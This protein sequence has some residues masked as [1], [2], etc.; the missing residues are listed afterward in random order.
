VATKKITIEN[1]GEVTLVKTTA[2]RSLRLTVNTSGTVRVSLP[3]WTP[4]AAAE[5]F[6]RSHTQWIMKELS[7]RAPAKLYTEAQKVGKLHH[8]HFEKVPAAV[9]IGSRV[10]ATKIIVKYHPGET[11]TARSVQERAEKAI[12][13]ALRKETEQLLPPRIRALA[14]KH[15]FRYRSIAAKQLKRRWGSC[16]SH[17]NL[18]FNFFLME[19][20]WEYID[21]VILHELTHTE[22]LHHGPA[23]WE[24]LKQ[25]CPAALDL[26]RRMREYRPMIGG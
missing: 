24:R 26:R 3:Y 18:V 21:Y 16:D 19:L 7:E 14:E 4:Y 22:H 8:L 15:G 5:A 11:T 17:H 20:P 13:R 25:T 1:V 9:T 23:F 10:T 2:S 12:Y 6:A